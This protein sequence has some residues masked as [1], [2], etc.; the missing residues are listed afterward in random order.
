MT[1]DIDN[2][3]VEELRATLAADF[4]HDKDELKDIRKTELRSMLK[5]AADE[6]EA[7]DNIDFGEEDEPG[8][9][10]PDDTEDVATVPTPGME[11]WHEF[12]MGQFMP[13]ELSAGNPTVD[14]MRRVVELLVSPI[15]SIKTN[16]LQ[17]P[18]QLMVKG[19]QQN[20]RR[21]TAIVTIELVD[22]TSFDGAADAY[23]G[24]VKDSMFAVYP[25]ALAETRAEGRAL[26]RALRL[27]KVNAAEEIGDARHDPTPTPE[28]NVE[29]GLITDNQVNC[30]NT[31]SGA[32][33]LNV[34]VVKLA[35]TLE[36]VGPVK[37]WTY[38]N[39]LAIIAQLNKFQNKTDEVPE[40]ITGHVTNWNS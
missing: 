18:E 12:V 14:G 33:K 6:A 4:G 15:K 37:T 36:I 5:E 27:R 3:T 17:V 40:S 13:D 32:T 8:D 19:T 22:E 28:G 11:E 35:E 38:A 23:W 9:F 16:L 1:L 34:N 10:T 39:A 25:V 26:K 29:E 21:A 20:D 7:V 31:M 2:M 24:N 30:L